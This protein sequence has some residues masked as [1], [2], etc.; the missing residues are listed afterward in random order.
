MIVDSPPI[1]KWQTNILQLCKRT[2]SGLQFELEV[3]LLTGERPDAE[4][5]FFNENLLGF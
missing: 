1:R 2:Q 5:I 4:H 3:M